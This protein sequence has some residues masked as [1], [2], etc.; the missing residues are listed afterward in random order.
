MGG[1][2]TNRSGTTRTQT[3]LQFECSIR[4]EIQHTE[5]DRHLQQR[6]ALEVVCKQSYGKLEG[7]CN[8]QSG[9]GQQYSE[10]QKFQRKG[11]QQ[12]K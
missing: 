5:T 3:V 7:H 9:S 12:C 6:L 8:V 2:Q 11:E 1:L 4:T 10:N